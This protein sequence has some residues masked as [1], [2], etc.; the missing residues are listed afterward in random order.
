MALGIATSASHVLVFLHNLPVVPFVIILFS[1]KVLVSCLRPNI[2]SIND[3][4]KYSCKIYIHH[5][6]YNALDDH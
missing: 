4:I 3:S 5:D 1:N 2:S 6:P